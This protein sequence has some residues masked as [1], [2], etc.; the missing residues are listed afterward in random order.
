MPSRSIFS[1][2]SSVVLTLCDLMDCSTPGLLVHHQLPKPT[3]THFH[4]VMM[5][6]N[7]LILCGPLPLLPS[8]FHSIRVFSIELV[9]C[10]RWPKYW[11]FNFRLVLPVNIQDWFSLDWLVGS[12]CSP[13]D[14]QE[15]SLTPQFK[16]INSSVLSFL[17]SPALTSIRDYWKKIIA[18]TRRTFAG[19]IMSLLFNMLSKLVITFLQRSK[20]L[21]ISGLQ[22]PFAVILE[23]R[24]IKSA[25]VS[26][27]SP[28][29]C[30]E[31]MG[32]DVMILVLW[33]LSFKSTFS[34]SSC[35]FIKRLF[36]SSSLVLKIAGSKIHLCWHK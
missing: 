27:V 23:P 21:L 4:Q 3:Q 1:S 2:V 7:H 6:S 28:S 18:L 32:P 25:T 22:S 15:S 24:K 19:K 30:H 17:Y 16:S 35:T 26:T 10:I 31:V 8:I 34:H 11:S 14:S 20:Q 29:I 33:M 13:R 5:P 9:L 36:S 12:P